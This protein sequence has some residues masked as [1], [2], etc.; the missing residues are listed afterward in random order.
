MRV[1]RAAP[2]VVDRLTAGGEKDRPIQA[3]LAVS[4]LAYLGGF[5]RMSLRRPLAALTSGLV[6]AAVTVAISPTASAEAPASAAADDP[7]AQVEEQARTNLLVNDEG[8]NLPPGSSFNSITPDINDD[9][10][11][12]FTVGVVYDDQAQEPY[13]GV[14]L[15]GHGEGG[16]VHELA[17]GDLV[18]SDITINDGDRLAFTRSP[19]TIDNQLWEYDAATGT[20]KQR[21]ALPVTPTGY[22]TP[23]ITDDGVIGARVQLGGGVGYVKVSPDDEGDLVASD[24]ATSGSDYHY[25][26]TPSFSESGAV[27]AKVGTDPDTFTPVEIRR[28]DPDGGSARLLANAPEDASS[29]YSAFDNTVSLN[30]DGKVAAIAT[31][32]GGGK[33]LLVTDG[34]TTDE[35]VTAGPDQQIRSFSSF[36]PNLNDAGDVVFRANDADGEAIYVYSDGELTRVAWK[37]MEVETDLGPGQIGQHDDSPVFGGGPRL[38]DNGDVVFTATLHPQGDNQ[39]EWGTGV[40]VAYAA[41]V[42]AEPG[43]EL[44][45]SQVSVA[46]GLWSE[47]T[48]TVELTNTSESSVSWTAADLPDW[49]TVAPSSGTLDAG[50]S[51]QLT[52]TATRAA[53]PAG[54]TTSTVSF[55]A[56]D[57]STS[58]DVTRS[59]APADAGVHAG[60][61][62]LTD[63]AGALWLAD[64]KLAGGNY[65]WVGKSGTQR[66][67]HAIAGTSDDAL[68][69]TRRTGR[70]SYKI[71][72]LPAGS[73]RL[74]LGFAEFDKVARGKRV[75]SVS[76]DGKVVLKRFDVAKS[77]GRYRAVWK[78]LKARHAKPGTMAVTLTP[79]KGRATVSALRV[80]ELR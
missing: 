28:F 36:P 29:P 38:N 78:S 80:T 42:P 9:G 32:T 15:G 48:E 7:Y 3:R 37:G 63:R 74:R 51:A 40:F 45:D 20:A 14:W 46:P 73:Y 41:S 76:V 34:E 43:L 22:S 72:G 49:L 16:I 58:L 68:F 13:P 1:G 60:G 50:A 57:L 26:Y 19:G 77:A 6:A 59:L 69:Q 44:D 56:G 70:V 39:T 64:R 62:R 10:E 25:L 47:A 21:F 12:A 52:L 27:A 24:S 11:V 65:G 66:T 4:L 55:T 30:S 75:F 17:E 33:V 23:Q 61:K 35:L 53:A 67:K 31:R 8:Y 54:E 5:S 2:A 79:I 71:T 18:S